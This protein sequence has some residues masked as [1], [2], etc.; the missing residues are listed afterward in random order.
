MTENRIIK[1]IAYIK[2]LKTKLPTTT[3][4]APL[5]AESIA[6]ATAAAAPVKGT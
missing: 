5:V 6:A 3:A 1:S 2:M 4:L